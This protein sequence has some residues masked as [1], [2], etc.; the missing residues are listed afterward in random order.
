MGST[1]T[2]ARRARPRGP[3][4]SWRATSWPSG[5]PS[6]ARPSR[7]RLLPEL[8]RLSGPR[9]ALEPALESAAVLRALARLAPPEI[10][11]PAGARPFF[12]LLGT[13]YSAAA[14]ATAALTGPRRVLGSG[15]DVLAARAF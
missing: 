4:S 10:V 11:G 6:R 7:S 9:L 8:R 14:R 1:G 13:R 5:A 15:L 3:R 2:F 12:S